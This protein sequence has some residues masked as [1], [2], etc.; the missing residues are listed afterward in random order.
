MFFV[1]S[2]GMY[3]VTDYITFTGHNNFTTAL[4][5]NKDFFDGLSE[6]D[7]QLIRDAVDVAFAFILEYQE[8]LTEASLEAI[9]E[10]K[11]GITITVLT[12]EER[13]PFMA[14]AEEVEQ[15]HPDDRR[16]RPEDPGPDEG[17]TSRT[18][19]AEVN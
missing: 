11:P 1:E 19:S 5:A 15:V 17:R 2:T 13:Q 18:A 8:G 10:A 4:M 7:Q 6:E 12:E 14:A 9:L 3:E 16:Q